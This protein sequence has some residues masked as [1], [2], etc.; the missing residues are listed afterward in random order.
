[1]NNYGKNAEIFNFGG[2]QTEKGLIFLAP[3]Q[4]QLS[5][6]TKKK[7][8]N[9][10]NLRIRLAESIRKYGVLQPFSVR[11]RQAENG[12]SCY[13]LVGEEER[14]RAVC[15]AGI[16]RIPCLVLSGEDKQCM[17]LSLIDEYLRGN[18]HFLDEA[19]LF[20]RLMREYSMKQTEIAEKCGLSQSSVANKLRLLQLTD[21]EQESVRRAGLGERHARSLLRIEDVRARQNALETV[22]LRHLSVTQTEELVEDLL[23]R[24]STQ[25]R[26]CIQAEPPQGQSLPD[27]EY[28]QGKA[29]KAENGDMNIHFFN[30]K[31]GIKAGKADANHQFSDLPAPPSAAPLRPDRASCKSPFLPQHEPTKRRITAEIPAPGGIMPRKFVLH[32]LQPLYNSIE[33]TLSIFQKTG[34]NAECM[35]EEGEDAVNIYIRIPRKKAVQ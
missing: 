29:G 14:F 20:E 21:R 34:M 17:A 4:I 6:H 32:D 1:M 13:Q 35:R 11:V 30:A 31:T 9:A 22:I 18:I 27:N 7:G 12:L 15:L 8:G 24:A 25:A 2:M 10:G 33:K 16:T 5:V 23:C 3:E 28:F 26:A 19:R